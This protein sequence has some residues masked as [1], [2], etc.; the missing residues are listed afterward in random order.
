MAEPPP[1]GDEC[2]CQLQEGGAEQR[3][4]L[5]LQ[6]LSLRTKDSAI[7]VDVEPSMRV[8]WAVDLDGEAHLLQLEHG[9]Y[10]GRK[11]ITQV[12]ASSPRNSHAPPQTL[13]GS[14]LG[15]AAQNGAQVHD[16]GIAL[17]D[18][19]MEHT[20][21]IGA[22]AVVIKVVSS[23]FSFE[24]L[25]E[26]DGVQIDALQDADATGAER[27]WHFN[28]AEGDRHE[29]RLEHGAR[30][31]K[32]LLDGEVVYDKGGFFSNFF[33]EEDKVTFDVGD[34]PCEI[35]MR[36]KDLG[37]EYFLHVDGRELAPTFERGKGGE[38]AEGDAN[39]YGNRIPESAGGAAAAP[40][41]GGWPEPEPQSAAQPAPTPAAWQSSLPPQS[42]PPPGAP[43]PTA[44]PPWHGAASTP[45][46]GPPPMAGLGPPPGGPPTGAG[47]PLG[48]PPGGRLGPPPGP[49]PALGGPP[50]GPPPG[51]AHAT[52]P[53]GLPP[54]AS[55]G[56]PPGGAPYWSPGAPT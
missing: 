33:L 44:V 29:V 35:V 32:V 27:A 53:P 47:P 43:P 49:P 16:S 52:G 6:S 55:S 54:A 17:I 45:P 34:R 21:H 8:K 36:E 41:A 31:R 42:S 26:V 38:S 9:D 50:P 11:T 20:L 10:T 18:R 46:P 1:A 22:H 14:G 40:A 37:F 13:T 56:P 28:D 30:R 2:A 19:G 7:V 3:V 5:Q 15:D 12:R 48:P 24:Y 39:V 51:A 4:I 23:A 25:C